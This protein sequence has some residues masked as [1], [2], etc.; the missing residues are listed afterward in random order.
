MRHYEGTDSKAFT[1]YNPQVLRDDS[2]MLAKW[3]K[4]KK[5]KIAPARSS[6][7]LLLSAKNGDRETT[8]LQQPPVSA[9]GYSS[10]SFNPHYPHNV[11]KE[12]TKQCKDCHISKENDNNAWMAQLFLHGTNFV[13]FFG[14]FVYLGLE[15]E[16]LEAVS[17]TE[18]EEPQAV[19]GSHAHKYAFPKEYEEH[20]TKNNGYLK[21]SYGHNSDGA[22]NLQLRGEYLFAAEGEDGFRVYDVANIDNKGFSQRIVTSPVSPFGQVP[23]IKSKFVTDLALPTNMTVDPNKRQL[24]ENKEHPMHPIYRYAFFTDRFEGLIGTDVTTFIDGNPRNNFIKRDV[25]FNPEG[26][27]SGAEAITLAGHI[28]YV[29]IKN[30]IKVLDL[31]NPIKP[32]II[33]EIKGFINPKRV[34][35]Q[36][37]YGFVVDDQGLKIFDATFPEKARLIEG[38][39]IALSEAYDVYVTRTYAYVAG[40]KSGLIII[41]VKNPEKPNVGTFFTLK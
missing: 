18:Y 24:P 14:K 5:G 34:A 17:I 33:N 12:E 36:F 19:I 31:N 7:A 26:Q 13:N 39:F 16:G 40:G 28:A 2:F 20:I 8:Y 21:E 15:D 11:R 30:S 1:T 10:Q 22:R 38:A 27:L 41:D 23:Y 25:T 37:R 3:D 6:S 9:S 29:S 4:N 35:I 32:K